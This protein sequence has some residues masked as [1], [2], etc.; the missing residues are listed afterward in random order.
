MVDTAINLPTMG[1]NILTGNIRYKL[2]VAILLGVQYE[3]GFRSMRPPTKALR[4]QKNTKLKRHIETRKKMLRIKF[5]ARQIMNPE[6]ASAHN[7]KNLFNPD[8]AAVSDFQCAA[9]N[10]PACH[11]GEDKRIK[12]LRIPVIKR[13]VYENVV[14]IIGGL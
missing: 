7:F 11:N 12:K 13:T 8:L 1:L 6:P 10:K 14:R 5:S 3:G 9:R 4:P 2:L